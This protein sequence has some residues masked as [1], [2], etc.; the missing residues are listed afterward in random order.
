ME[1]EK[2]VQVRQEKFGAVVFE[3]LR[4]KVFVGNETA[5]DIL[6][7]RQEGK[8]PEQI[9]SE[10]AESYDADRA[11]I[12]ADV[13]EFVADLKEKGIAKKQEQQSC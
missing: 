8:S 4:E 6:R 1:F 12:E 7:L 10:L 3:T 11:T 9:V 13:N 2:H 5:A